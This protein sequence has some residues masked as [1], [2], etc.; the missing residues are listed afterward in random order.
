MRTITAI[1]TV[2]AFFSVAC[3]G[4]GS[5]PADEEREQEAEEVD[6]DTVDGWLEARAVPL[7]DVDDLEPVVAEAAERDLILLGEASHGTAEFYDWRADL[8]LAIAERGG[9]DFVAV[10][11]DWHAARAADRF[12]M[13]EGAVDDAEELVVHAF[14]R[15]P[16]WMWANEEFA[17]FLTRVRQHNDAHPD[18]P[19]RIYGMDMHG[20]YQSLERLVEIVER[21]HPDRATELSTHLQC[22]ARFAPELQRYMGALRSGPGASCQSDIELA[23]ELTETL[24]PDDDPASVSARKHARVVAS[25][26][27]QYRGRIEQGPAAFWN[28]RA[29]HMFDVVQA[30]LDVHGPDARGAVWAHNTHIGD[31]RATDKM[32]QRGRVNIGQLSRQSMGTDRVLAVGFSTNRGEVIA[33]RQ[34]DTPLQRMEVPRA[35][36]GSVDEKLNRFDSPQYFVVFEE[37]DEALPY[38]SMRPGQRA[39]GVIYHPE[40]EDPG[41]YVGT[42]PAERYDALIFIEKTSALNPL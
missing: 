13:G 32:S 37:G 4:C 11:G 20:V 12:V 9:L 40:R 26:E 21:D 23:V 41:N 19:I 28:V 16:Q 38:W 1:I 33:G 10:E 29:T 8:S 3:D 27:A 31:A 14:Q 7:D 24:Y 36:R 34:W 15:W 18:R 2:F 17:S 6:L 35:P 5:P 22:L 39:M 25:G 30:L 42:N